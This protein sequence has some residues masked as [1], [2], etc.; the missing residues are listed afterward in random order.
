MDFL[1]DIVVEMIFEVFLEG[2]TNSK[3]PEPIRFILLSLFI[4]I[5]SGIL[6]LAVSIAI[7]HKS[8]LAW[9]CAAVILFIGIGAFIRKFKEHL[10]RNT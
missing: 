1:L 2:A 8:I 9:I 3:V 6:Y 7:E 5:Y 4:M 10:N